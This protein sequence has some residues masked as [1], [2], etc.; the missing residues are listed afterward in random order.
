[1]EAREK[2]SVLMKPSTK[3]RLERLKLRLRSAGIPRSEATETAV[4]EALVA[5]ADYDALLRYFERR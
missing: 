1:M 4:I 5:L 3:N 2:T